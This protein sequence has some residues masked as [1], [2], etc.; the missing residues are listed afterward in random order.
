MIRY[1]GLAYLPTEYGNFYYNVFEGDESD[2][3]NQGHATFY[4][5]T[6]ETYT[7]DLFSVNGVG[8]IKSIEYP[9]ELTNYEATINYAQSFV[10]YDETIYS[11]AKL[12]YNGANLLLDSG[13]VSVD[14]A[15]Y[16]TMHV[17]FILLINGRAY[18]ADKDYYE[19]NTALYDFVEYRSPF[20]NSFGRVTITHKSPAQINFFNSI[21]DNIQVIFTGIRPSTDPYIGGGESGSGKGD[22]NFDLSSD[23]I[24]LPQTP[25][26]SV[27]DTNFITLYNP[28]VGDLR[29][30]ASYMWSDS[31]FDLDNFKKLFADP[32]QAILGLSIV[33]VIP[34]IAGIKAVKIGNISTDVNMQYVGS[35]Y[36]TIDCGSVNVNEFWG[37]Y[38]DYDPYTKIEIY[39]PY[40]GTHALSADDV[41]G[42]S[43][44]VVYHVDVLSGACA[45][46]IK[47]DDSVLYSFIGQCSSSIPITG[48]NWTN[49]ING[50]LSIAGAVGSMVAT[51][52]ATAPLAVSSIASTVVNSSKPSIERSGSM[53]GT[54][55]MMS[56]QT[57]YLI[58][59]R[60]RQ[61]VPYAQNKFIGYPTFVTVSLGSISG[62]NEIDSIRLNSI[63]AATSDEY[64]EIET[65]LKGGVIF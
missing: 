36:V 46:Y 16:R 50:A 1:A 13:F 58:I 55:G 11:G 64:N 19:V 38:L 42:K 28:N 4:I 32:M 35:Q 51:E 30:L 44:N 24:P 3:D 48:D 62:Y 52:G 18:K 25:L 45:A 43:L 7:F 40:I 26:V 59:S 39:L 31:L 15:E 9:V 14:P 65:L 57:P 8:E 33:P 23:P 63:S 60:P 6:G 29:A 21:P 12:N 2:L 56:I 61:A 20:P 54:G 17:F 22:G 10:F 34:N 47:C 41:M 53:S 49:V 27:G 5:S 37:A